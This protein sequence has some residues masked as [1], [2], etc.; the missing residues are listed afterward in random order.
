MG[1]VIQLGSLL[2]HAISIAH[3]TSINT[4]S[5]LRKQNGDGE[6][7]LTLRI[8]GFMDFVHCTGW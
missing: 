2:L 7:N 1:V 3:L 8:T 5:K 6:Y 4:N